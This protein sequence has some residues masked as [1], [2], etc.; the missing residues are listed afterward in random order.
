MGTQRPFKPITRSK[1]L[2]VEGQDEKN[3][4]SKLITCLDLPDIE[5]R[6]IGGKTK[7]RRNIKTLTITSGYDR[8]TSVGIVT[9]ADKQPQGAFDS[10]CDA[11]EAAGLPR[12][13][14]PLRPTGD[15]PQVAVMILPGDGREGMLEDLYLESV[16]DDPVMPCLEEHFRCLEEQLEAGAFP[17]NPSKAIVRTFLASME[18]LEEAHF[19]YLQ[20]RMGEY[21]PELPNAPSVA[22]VHTFLASRYKPDLDLGIAAKKGY[23]RLDHPAFAQVKQFLST[24]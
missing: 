5:I 9:D 22:K 14:A 15:D 4:F 1:V 2:V 24:L 7:F 3:L 6:D 12:P 11:L 8:V 19:E 18:W 20:K 13:T 23:W 16:A 17:G 21:L 10:I